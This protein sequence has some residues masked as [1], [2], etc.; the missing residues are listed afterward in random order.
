MF[1]KL[2]AFFIQYRKTI[3]YFNAEFSELFEWMEPNFFEIIIN[4]SMV[5]QIH[6]H[7]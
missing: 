3:E 2:R 6:S 1:K 5:L 4:Q 7:L